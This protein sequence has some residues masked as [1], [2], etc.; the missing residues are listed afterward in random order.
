MIVVEKYVVPD[1]ISNIRLVDY[2]FKVLENV[3][4]KS[5][6]KKAIKRGEI[7]IDGNIAEGGRWILPGQT[8]ELV[9]LKSHQPK[10]FEMPL[11]V[12]F[13]DDFLAV[14][15]KPAGISVSGNKFKT[16]V[17]AL[18][19]NLKAS[20]Q[21]DAL[22]YPKPVHRLDYATSGLLL[23]AKT[24]QTLA[25]LGKYFEKRQIKKRYRAIV[26][27]KTP[28]IGT[29]DQAI[30]GQ[31]A[32]TKYELVSHSRS[33]HTEW[34][35]LVDLYPLT[36]RT[37][38]LRIH[39]SGAGYP[40]LGDKMYDKGERVLQ[41]KGLFLA[42]VEL[43]FKHPIFETDITVSIDMPEKFSRLLASQQR[44]WENYN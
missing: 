1:G 5:S 32:A 8:I 28:A 19:Y 43:N 38:Q 18:P 29:I 26:V 2:A 22:T 6:L 17:N 21:N 44:R 24:S 31:Q 34:L 35:S 27:G 36:G 41:K 12:V 15:N 39:M 3:P 4:T 23:V 20:K 30:N 25:K 7:I 11:E 37:H 40:I 9:D 16:I 33:L 13:E 42:A 10:V 14:I